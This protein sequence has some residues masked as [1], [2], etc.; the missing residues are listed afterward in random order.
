MKNKLIGIVIC[1]MML[2][3]LLPITA[4]ATTIISESQTTNATGRITND[5]TTKKGEVSCFGGITSP[6]PGYLY[7]FGD[8]VFPLKS[9]KTIILFGDILVESNYTTEGAPM[10]TVQ[11][12]LDDALMNE[13]TTAPYS[14][15]IGMKHNGPATIKVIAIDILGHSASA[16]LYIDYYLKLV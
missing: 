10:R 11:F 14:V 4:L 5:V 9:G 13:D 16:T 15:T 2:V 6:V 3:T 12:Y 1:V 7:L 8:Q